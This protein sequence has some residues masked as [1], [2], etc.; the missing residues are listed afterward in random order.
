VDKLIASPRF[1]ERLASEWLD[2]A[3]YA[4]TH[5]YQMDRTRSMWAWRDWVIRAF[6]SN[7]RYDQFVTLQLAGDLLPGSTQE[8]QLA[9]GFNRLHCQNEE[10]GIV[11]EEYRVA[12]VV[13]RVNTFATAFLGLTTECARCHDH[14]YDP[15]TQ[16]D[17]YSL[18]AFF[19]NVDESGQTTYF[20]DST[21]VPTVLLSTPEQ[22]KQIAALRE[23][24]ANAEK[25]VTDARTQGKADFVVWMDKLPEGPHELAPEGESARYQFDVLGKGTSPGIAGAS[26]RRR[27]KAQTGGRVSG[28]AVALDGDNGF[29]LPGAGAFNRSSELYVY[30]L[31]ESSR[32]QRARCRFPQEQGARRCGQSRLRTPPGEWPCCVRIASHVA[33]QLREGGDEA[34]HSGW[35][36]D[37]CLGDV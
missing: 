9:T 14:K 17:F 25:T 24:I 10:G 35:R 28:K 2:V 27:T 23:K 20:T 16:R 7:M 33:G 12:Y 32:A 1:G 18:F 19:Q 15:F 3:R 5:G 31:A 6:N 37:S 11:G 21:P 22:D 8:Q 13:D 30:A 29:T 34:S 4:D 36:V 26:P